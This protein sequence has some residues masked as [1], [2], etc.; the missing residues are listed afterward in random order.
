LQFHDSN[1]TFSFSFAAFFKAAFEGPFSPP[2]AGAS[3]AGSVTG[4]TFSVALSDMFACMELTNV[5]LCGRAR[6]FGGGIY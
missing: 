5:T 6:G 4:T 3:W 2:S 1:P